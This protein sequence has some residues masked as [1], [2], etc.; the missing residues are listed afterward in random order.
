MA[1]NAAK[2]PELDISILKLVNFLPQAFNF[3]SNPS[4]LQL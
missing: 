3:A 2:A 1:K 4:I